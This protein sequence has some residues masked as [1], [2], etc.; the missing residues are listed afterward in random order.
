[1]LPSSTVE[2]YL[3]AIYQGQSTLD[4]GER[5][6]PMGQVAAALRVAPDEDPNL[7]DARRP[8]PQGGHIAM[9]VGMEVGIPP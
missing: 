1:M 9:L 2:N 8:L 3:K 5:L 7:P 6:V 4:P